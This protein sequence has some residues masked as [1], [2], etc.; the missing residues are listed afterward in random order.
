M[1]LVFLCLVWFLFPC[2][3]RRIFWGNIAR[4]QVEESAWPLSLVPTLNIDVVDSGSEESDIW[5]GRV[6]RWGCLSVALCQSSNSKHSRQLTFFCSFIINWTP[7]ER[8]RDAD[9]WKLEMF[10]PSQELI[11]GVGFLSSF[12]ERDSFI[13]G[14]NA[15]LYRG[16]WRN[17]S[18]NTPKVCPLITFIE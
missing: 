17:Q 11:A 3:L 4:R 16:V 13:S 2:R 10:D 9:L 8:R 12:E 7:R 14:P 15:Y 1:F 6:V 18:S 5:D